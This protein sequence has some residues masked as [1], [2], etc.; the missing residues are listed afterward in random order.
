MTVRHLS[1][2]PAAGN[3][4]DHP[5]SSS[6]GDS[7]YDSDMECDVSPGVT[8]NMHSLLP[9]LYLTSSSNATYRPLPPP[10]PRPGKTQRVP[11][12]P[13][14]KYT[15]TNTSN[16]Q[17]PSSKQYS[18]SQ[19]PTSPPR[20]QA[21]SRRQV[22]QSKVNSPSPPR[23]RRRFKRSPSNKL[24]KTV[25]KRVQRQVNL[26]RLKENNP[27]EANSPPSPAIRR[28]L[29]ATPSRPAQPKPTSP[30]TLFENFSDIKY[31]SS[32][33][34]ANLI[35]T[36][37]ESSLSLVSIIDTRAP[38]EFELGHIKGSINIFTKETMQEYFD[39]ENGTQHKPEVLIFYS[40]NFSQSELGLA[41]FLRALDAR[42]NR[43]TTHRLTFPRIYLLNDGFKTFQNDYPDLCEAQTVF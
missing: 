29:Q 5:A 11:P 39:L 27:A 20:P 25:L 12:P 6:S 41:H 42:I 40:Q 19:S 13:P 43:D 4:S 36:S 28:V 15:V 9:K 16:S 17:Q 37:A 35:C 33:S 24:L 26:Q 18:S 21:A 30:A 7:G 1:T 3:T 14:H 31:V 8:L 32:S 34:V 23:V 38:F 22:L 10:P 2:D